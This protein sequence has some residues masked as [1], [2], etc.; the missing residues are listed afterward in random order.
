MSQVDFFLRRRNTAQSRD[1][2]LFLT[3]ESDDVRGDDRMITPQLPGHTSA[4]VTGDGA[5]NFVFDIGSRQIQVQ[6]DGFLLP[7]D[8][9]EFP[10]PLPN[11]TD[12]YLPNEVTTAS[13][14]TGKAFRTHLYDFWMDQAAGTDF[15]NFRLGYPD[16]GDTDETIAGTGYRIWHG[17]MTKPR[18]RHVSG[19]VDQ[20]MFSI[21]FI[22]GQVV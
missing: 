18:T 9:D 13:D 22:V 16:W 10:S 2:Y 12:I 5:P 4:E 17:L 1:E 20:F 7:V 6:L 3:A 11:G 8:A 21:N 15:T 19:E 14:T